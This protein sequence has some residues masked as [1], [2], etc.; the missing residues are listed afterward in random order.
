MTK[1]NDLENQL[2]QVRKKICEE[3]YNSDYVGA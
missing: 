3:V 1:E 2:E